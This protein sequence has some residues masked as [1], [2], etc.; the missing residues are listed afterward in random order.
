M[1]S[2]TNTVF[3]NIKYPALIHCKSGADRAG[4]VG[5][6]YKILYCNE[7]PKIAKEQLSLKYLHVKWAKTGILDEFIN[8]YES[9]FSKIKIPTFLCG[10]KTIMIPLNWKK[11]SKKIN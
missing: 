5:A 4:I 8:E 11:N 10:L 2:K 6:L 3:N 7:E 1:I 9:Y